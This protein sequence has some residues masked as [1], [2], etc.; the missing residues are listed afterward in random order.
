MD[1]YEAK[2]KV[3]NVVRAIPNTNTDRMENGL[4]PALRARTSSEGSR[5]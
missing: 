4:R 1:Q 3:Q 2:F 5:E